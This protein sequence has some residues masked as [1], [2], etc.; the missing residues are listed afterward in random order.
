MQARRDGRIGDTLLLLEHDPV[1]T[2][3]RGAKSENL[4]LTKENL[5]VRGIDLVSTHRGGDVTY[6]GPGQLVAYPIVDLAPDRQDVRRYVRDL[7]DVMT[8]LASDYGIGAGI[9]D[10]YPG[11]WVDLASP[12]QWPGE[13]F[14]RLPAK[15]GAVGVRISQWITMHGFALNAQ[16]HMD[17]F[18]VIVPCGIRKHGVT[19]LKELTNHA[20][21]PEDMAE[22][23]ATL[24]CERLEAK[25]D[26]FTRL[27]VT[28]DQLAENLN[29]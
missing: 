14:A 22:R 1:V 10:Q 15:L 5:A 25:L 27:R 11:I 29:L 19:S 13:H 3:G 6:H 12:Q 9:I 2:L 23:A 28:D 18:S 21:Q 7:L 16:T 26:N 17:G 20:P 24:L 4:L 8:A